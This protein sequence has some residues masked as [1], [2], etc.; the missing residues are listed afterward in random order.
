MRAAT[1]LVYPESTGRLVGG[2]VAR[3]RYSADSGAMKSPA[4]FHA[5]IASASALYQIDIRT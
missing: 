5:V 1:C 2:G 4:Q 3:K